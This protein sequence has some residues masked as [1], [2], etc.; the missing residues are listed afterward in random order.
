MN[1]VGSDTQVFEQ[2]VDFGMNT[3]GHEQWR[4]GWR[5]VIF[6]VSVGASTLGLTKT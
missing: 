4:W 2:A 6:G 3:F 1:T 5:R